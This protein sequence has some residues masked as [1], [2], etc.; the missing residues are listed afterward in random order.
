MIFIWKLTYQPITLIQT[1]VSMSFQV[2]KTKNLE[3]TTLCNSYL[4]AAQHSLDFILV[5]FLNHYHHFLKNELLSCYCNWKTF[6]LNVL[7]YV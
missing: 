4:V 7:V 1:A 3:K 2:D 5:R 6:M